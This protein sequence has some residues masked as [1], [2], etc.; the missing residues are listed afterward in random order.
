MDHDFIP[1]ISY[2]S[3]GILFSATSIVL[4]TL[5]LKKRSDIWLAI[6]SLASAIW[7]L[8]SAVTYYGI[9]INN[10]IISTLEL[11]RSCLWIIML[12]IYLEVNNGKPITNQSHRSLHGAW[13]AI[14]LF[15]LYNIWLL[16]A[17][18]HL[19][20]S[21]WTGLALSIT[22]IVSVEQLYR[23]TH[24][25]RLLKL[26]SISVATFFAY[27][28][29]LFSHSLI[30]SRADDDLEQARGA[31]NGLSAIAIILGVIV[32][33]RHDQRPAQ[34]TVSRPVIFY[35]TALTG[36]GSFLTLI[37]VGG[38]YIQT[39][40]GTWG[41]FL[42][43]LVLFAALIFISVVLIS[44]TARS[45]FTV[46]IN[47]NFFHHKYDYRVEW[48]RLINS[49]SR[50]ANGGDFSRRAIATV[51]SIFKS[52]SGGLWLR[53]GEVFR[54]TCFYNMPTPAINLKEPVSTAFCRA[55]KD[56]EW[57]FSPSAPA[58]E[59][60]GTLNE[61]LPA[62][63]QQIPQLWLVMP[64]LTEDELLGFMILT[65]PNI[66]TSLTW[67]DLDL[68][69]TVGRQVA[70]YLYRHEAA[71]LLAEARQ[72]DAFNKLTAF[73]MHDLKNLIAQQALV[74]QNAAKHKE[75]PAFVEDAIRTID[76][77]V[78]RMNNLLKRLQQNEPSETRSTS[79]TSALID[80]IKKCQDAQ[81]LPSLRIECED[82]KISTDYD[83]FIMVLTHVIQNAQEA[84][85][86]SGFI[87]VILSATNQ[88][89]VIKIEDNGRGMTEDFLRNH[90][91]KPFETTK[92]G[93][94]MGIGAYQTK[95]FV[96]SLGGSV[97]VES[98]VGEGTTFTITI[99]KQLRI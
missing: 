88:D 20:Q 42:S 62:W 27:D 23:N 22:G 19:S 70:S 51:A 39:Y 99:P 5:W 92:S 69:K 34:I 82:I 9:P 86:E 81:P 46:W 67:E 25:S 43:I 50:P 21:T 24:H 65:E 54:P 77:S 73:I 6:P 10:Q 58:D 98:N 60:L 93:K 80:A 63:T 71:E 56:N 32:T 59:K 76:N 13:I 48:L 61:Y 29:Y 57:V 18:P 64:L 95:E 15:A 12:L 8:A 30:F 31:V 11:L 90:L 35:T 47:K 84:T 49:L 68:L 14:S 72:F 7:L 87:D 75:N 91:F 52:P 2:A 26:I 38:Y 28:I 44:K 78:K 4:F 96:N 66:D 94:G 37:A 89:L 17:P 1:L 40:G 41:N 16:K 33:S 45:F 79:V 3:G 97:L 83:G 85:P 74:V 53:E 36:V 55:M